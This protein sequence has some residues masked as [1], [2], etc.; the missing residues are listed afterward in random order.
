MVLN[1]LRHFFFFF[2]ISGEEDFDFYRLVIIHITVW[3]SSNSLLPFYLKTFQCKNMANNFYISL[4]FF[5]KPKF[6][7]CKGSGGFS[8]GLLLNTWENHA[9]KLV[10]H[11]ENCQVTYLHQTR[12]RTC[13]FPSD[14]KTSEPS[15]VDSYYMC[16][17][18]FMHNF[19]RFPTNTIENGN[20][21]HSFVCFLKFPFAVFM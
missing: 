5:F 3:S 9:L 18:W 11:F 15:E 7:K 19:C 17:S 4:S 6:R 12:I 16:H 1:Y 21:A 14:V 8:P 10:I 2:C 20:M 13:L